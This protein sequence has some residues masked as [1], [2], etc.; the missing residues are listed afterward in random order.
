MGGVM[1]AT[2]VFGGEDHLESHVPSLNG[3]VFKQPT[4]TRFDQRSRVT[5]RS[6]GQ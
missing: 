2:R 5:A 3:A 6:L 1:Q 4:E